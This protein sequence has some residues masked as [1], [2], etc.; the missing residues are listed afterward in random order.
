M[1]VE[2]NNQR[3]RFVAAYN[4]QRRCSTPID[5]QALEKALYNADRGRAQLLM[6][7]SRVLSAGWQASSSDRTFQCVNEEHPIVSRGF[8]ALHDVVVA[9][10]KQY[11][12]SM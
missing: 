7:S 12:P 1:K 3:L 10:C 9:A 5:P 8:A 4:A 2:A 11:D 6:R